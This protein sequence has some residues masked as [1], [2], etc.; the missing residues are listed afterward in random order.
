MNLYVQ[1]IGG[2]GDILLAMMRPGAALGYF[3]AL[4]A[5]G[6]ITMIEAH[7]NADVSRVLF[8]DLPHVDHLR[9]RGYSQ[10]FDTAPG[11]QFERLKNWSGLPWVQPRLA[12]QPW[13]KKIIADISV[14]PYVA[15]HAAASLP[16][17]VPPRTEELLAKLAEARVRTV[18]VGVEPYDNDKAVKGNRTQGF[19]S[20]IAKYPQHIWLPPGLRLHIAAVQ[21]ARKFIGT[22]SCFNCAAQLAAVPSFVIVNRAL[23][24][25]K[26]YGMMAKNNAIIEPWND[27]T[28][29][30]I[31]RI[32][33]D[34]A[35]WAR[36]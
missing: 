23:K 1:F 12:L 21:A 35:E 14:E 17:K 6:D 15:V 19:R 25:P 34:A 8:E 33:R 7:V 31:E 26:V 18:L 16:E 3:P 24:E 4:K 28:S 27:V 32:Y 29:G 36:R 9:F 13:E 5:R 2:I 30:P 20:V 10:K 11:V 22:L